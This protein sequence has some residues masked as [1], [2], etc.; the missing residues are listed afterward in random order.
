MATRKLS[1]TSVLVI[2]G[3]SGI[4]YGVVKGLVEHGASNVYISSSRQ[5]KIDSTIAR[6]RETYPDDIDTTTRVTGIPCDLSDEA[7]LESNVK[8][9]YAAIPNK[10]DHVV[11]TAGDTLGI[12][13]L[14]QVDFAF[15]KQAGMVRFFAPFLVTKYARDHL[16]P[17]VA[18]SVTLTTGGVSEKPN[19][20]WSAITPYMTGLHGMCRQFALELAP[21]RVNIVSPG[22]VRTELWDGSFK[23]PKV[24]DAAFQQYAKKMTTGQVGHV[25]DVAESYLYSMKDKNCTGTVIRSDGGAFLL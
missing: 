18:S 4:G 1:G 19:P 10:L 8:G 5:S 23:D 15:F 12:K 16:V 7:N 24:R 25:E 9:L 13:P 17:G 14:D 22:A 21:I 20:N 3:T 6:L 2:G 11:F